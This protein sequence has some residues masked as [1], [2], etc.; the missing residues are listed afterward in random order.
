MPIHSRRILSL[1]S[2]AD[3]LS[4]TIQTLFL[5][6]VEMAEVSKNARKLGKPQAAYDMISLC[7]SLI[8]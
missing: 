6:P 2:D 4:K 1:E 3:T 7:E 5:D 8:K